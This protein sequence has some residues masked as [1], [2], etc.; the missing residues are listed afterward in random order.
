MAVFTIIAIA[1]T[2]PS[3]GPGDEPPPPPP[4]VLHRHRAPLSQI[5]E[6]ASNVENPENPCPTIGEDCYVIESNVVPN[7]TRSSLI[8][9]LNILKNAISSN[10]VSSYFSSQSNYA[11]MFPNLTGNNDS[12]IILQYLIDGTYQVAMLNDNTIAVYQNN[13]LT[14]ENIIFVVFVNYD[15]IP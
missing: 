1:F 12:N 11:I 2:L 13:A 6:Q 8:E 9:Q 15:N 10:T 5:G 14:D 3:C 4:K 7:A